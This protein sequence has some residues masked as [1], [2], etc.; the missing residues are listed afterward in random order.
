MTGHVKKFESSYRMSEN[1]VAFRDIF[2]SDADNDKR[3]SSLVR[4]LCGF[5]N[6]D[7][8]VESDRIRVLSLQQFNEKV[9]WFVH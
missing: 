9:T 2:P 1:S 6:T 5:L 3:I 7:Y 4:S 8:N